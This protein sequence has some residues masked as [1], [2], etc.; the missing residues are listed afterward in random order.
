[1]AFVPF[2]T[3]VSALS[4]S[5]LQP[6][7]LSPPLLAPHG[8]RA[9]DGPT[10]A[11]AVFLP[12]VELGGQLVWS[13]LPISC[14]SLAETSSLSQE[15]LCWPPRREIPVTTPQTPVPGKWLRG[16]GHPQ[17]TS[18]TL[19]PPAF[20][21]HSVTPNLPPAPPDLCPA[22]DASFI[23]YPAPRSCTPWLATSI[24]S[25]TACTPHPVSSS[26][27]RRLQP[28]RS[29]FSPLCC[30]IYGGLVGLCSHLQTWDGPGVLICSGSLWGSGLLPYWN[31]RRAEQRTGRQQDCSQRDAQKLWGWGNQG[32]SVTPCLTI[33]PHSAH[34]PPKPPPCALS[35]PWGCVLPVLHDPLSPAVM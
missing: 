15:I 9:G 1:M 11:L 19:H 28:W 16:S 25:L 31:W 14:R 30:W 13:P 26:L 23:L 2:P 34:S 33:N 7:F 4:P 3:P 12:R 21:L 5:W 20:V 35:Q 32:G 24:P 22:P 27:P 18:Y 10:G 29:L 6:C 8:H 17:T